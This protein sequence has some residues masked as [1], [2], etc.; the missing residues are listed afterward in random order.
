[1]EEHPVTHRDRGRLRRVTRERAPLRQT[2]VDE[3]VNRDIALGGIGMRQVGRDAQRMV[4][5]VDRRPFRQEA[6][7]KALPLKLSGEERGRG[8][9][10][11]PHEALDE[12]EAGVTHGH[13]V[14]SQANN[15]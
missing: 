5:V 15:K 14:V 9:L 7:G 1:M 2:P 3:A 12:H 6:L 4:G 11:G 8:R 13:L 10:A